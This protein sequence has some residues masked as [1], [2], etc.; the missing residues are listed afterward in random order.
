MKIYLTYGASG[1][2][3]VSAPSA[4][5]ST[6]GTRGL[7]DKIISQEATMMMTMQVP[8]RRSTKTSTAPTAFSSVA[9]RPSTKPPSVSSEDSSSSSCK[10]AGEETATPSL[11]GGLLARGTTGVLVLGTEGTALA[12]STTTATVTTTSTCNA[13]AGAL[14]VGRASRGGKTICSGGD[15]GGGCKDIVTADEV[16]EV[17]D[18]ADLHGP[19]KLASMNAQFSDMAAEHAVISQLLKKNEVLQNE[20]NVSALAVLYTV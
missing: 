5:I 1:Q 18:A 3:Q 11:P 4:L 10:G 19:V 12:P 7:M 13:I 6:K 16:F 20:V 15:G 8:P 2:Q 17:R 14:P 9:P